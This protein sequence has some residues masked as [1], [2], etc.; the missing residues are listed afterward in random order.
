MRFIVFVKSTKGSEAEL[1]LTQEQ[2]A[3][4]REMGKFNE[5]MVKAGVMLAADGLHASSKGA[6]I[7]WSRGKRSVTDGPFTES[8]ELIAGFWIIQVKSIEEAIEWISRAPFGDDNE[9][10]IRQIVEAEDLGEAFTADLR[11]AEE[12]MRQQLTSK[13]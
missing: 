7:R 1:P 2:V 3:D 13:Q 5:E 10:E 9:V 11:E 4:M 6:R 8:K 12:R